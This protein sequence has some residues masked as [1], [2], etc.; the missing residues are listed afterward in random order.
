MMID[1]VGGQDWKM[2]W[3]EKRKC[4]RTREMDRCWTI[5]D[6]MYLDREIEGKIRGADE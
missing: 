2:A 6:G 1:I 4:A 5:G 3:F